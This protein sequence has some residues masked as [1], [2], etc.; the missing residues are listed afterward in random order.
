MNI[1][2]LVE[3]TILN[4]SCKAIPTQ[5]WTGQQGSRRLQL[6]EFPDNWHMKVARLSALLTGHLYPQEIH[7]VFISVIGRVDPRA[8]V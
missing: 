7:L 3:P 8:T 5:A 1:M 4:L 6:L 2:K